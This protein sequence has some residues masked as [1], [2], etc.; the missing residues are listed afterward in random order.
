[1]IE[2][3][4]FLRLYPKI[5]IL[6][7][8]WVYRSPIFG[9]IARLANFFNVDMGIENLV[10]PLKEKV[11]EGYS[12]LIFPEGHRS[13][14]GHIQRFH[15][16]AFFLAEKL[17][18]D[19]LPMM[20]FGSGDFL[21]RGAFWGRPNSLRMK[22][23]PRVAW[24]D[25]SFGKTYQER[26][27]QFR[28]YYV[29]A[30]AGFKSAEGDAHYYKRTL[31]LNY[32]LKGPVLE[33][34]MRVKLK[35]E[36]NY[37]IYCKL[38]PRT[39]EILDLGCGYGFISYMLMLTSEDRRITGIDYDQE[40]IIVA[41]NGFSKND[42]VSFVCAD[43]S[44]VEITPKSGFLLS[45]VLHYLSSDHQERLLR[46]CFSNLLPGGTILIREANADLETRHQRSKL[47][48]LFS[49]RTGFNKTATSS[50]EL[51]FTSASQIE[52][53]AKD[54]GLALEVIDNKK[55]TSNNLFVI[56]KL[57]AK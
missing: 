7:T 55:L 11:L 3:P 1:L 35:L 50:K 49:T 45:D 32:V 22:V 40:K 48:E 15:R 5:L 4:A 26:A 23:M 6:T 21:G 36:N 29:K 14:D 30:Y 51:H 2:T 9:P 41:S 20:V 42:R 18:I 56:K 34:Y 10:E 17:Q 12:I 43:V 24:N 47:T 38:L 16:G 52:A 57:Q 39:G 27:R 37:D 31:A 25:E 54:Y 53:I 8:S 28:Q 33:W 13:E 44:D 19:I 46:K